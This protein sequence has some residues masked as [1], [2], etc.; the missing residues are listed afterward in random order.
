MLSNS[1]TLLTLDKKKKASIKLL[2]FV[3]SVNVYNQHLFLRQL[4]LQ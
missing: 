2:A 3:F 4:T 1:D